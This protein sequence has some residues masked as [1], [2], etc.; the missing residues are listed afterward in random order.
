MMEC[1][2]KIRQAGVPCAL[3]KKPI[4]SVWDSTIKKADLPRYG[5]VGDFFR[6]D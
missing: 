2:V 4:E 3:F 5:W 1:I 6:K